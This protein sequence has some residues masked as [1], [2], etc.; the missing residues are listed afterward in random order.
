M[1]TGL[2]SNIQ[3]Y[4]LHDGPGI[5]TTV[6]LKGCPLSC[7]WCHNPENGASH[8]EI[9]TV[10]SRCVRCGECS[11]TCPSGL[12]SDRGTIGQGNG[13]PCRLCGA[14]VEACPTGA[15]QMVGK[16]MTV[17]EVMAEIRKDAIFYEDS[18]GGVTFS[19]GEPLAQ[20]AFL[21]ALVESCAACGI[22]TALDTCGFAPTGRLLAVAAVV[23]L[24]LYDIKSADDVRHTRFT[25]VSNRLI[26]NNLRILGQ[27]HGNIWLRIPVIPGLNDTEEELDAMARLAASVGGVRQI[28]LLP[29][30]RTATAKFQ[31]MGRANE[32][33]DVV[34]PSSERMQSILNRFTSLRLAARVGG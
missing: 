26:L 33:A 2:V 9:M 30:H 17:E 10:E 22:R 34:P 15:R 5:R 20:P 12:L 16:R 24:V 27:A 25:G 31:R 18:G 29:Y 6:F 19:G 4:S 13:A 32:L 14:C 7:L 8:T 28:N 11:D 21:Q 23:D 1:P 3:R